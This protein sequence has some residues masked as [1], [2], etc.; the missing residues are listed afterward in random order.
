MQ[1]SFGR[2]LGCCKDL[3]WGEKDPIDGDDQFAIQRLR[4]TNLAAAFAE[5][6]EGLFQLRIRRHILFEFQPAGHVA[7]A[8][9]DT[10]GRDTIA[11]TEGDSA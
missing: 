6:V 7:R 11:G 5:L 8:N 2:D 4:F 10:L 1:L 9:S 3:L